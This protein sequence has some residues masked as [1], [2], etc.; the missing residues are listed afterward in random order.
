[1]GLCFPYNLKE[2]FGYY[3]INFVEYYEPTVINKYGIS[4]TMSNPTV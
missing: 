1:M 4:E 2:E 3:Y